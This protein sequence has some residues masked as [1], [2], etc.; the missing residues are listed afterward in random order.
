MFAKDAED[1]LRMTVEQLKSSRRFQWGNLILADL[2]SILANEIAG[3]DHSIEWSARKAL[4]TGH[5]IML[6]TEDELRQHAN[7]KGIDSYVNLTKR[8]DRDYELFREISDVQGV[9]L[10]L[11]DHGESPSQS[12]ICMHGSGEEQMSG[13]ASY[14]VEI[15]HPS[16]NGRPEVVFHVAKGNPCISIYTAIPLVFPVDEDVMSQALGMYFR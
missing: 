7:S 6:E 9:F 5:H 2:D 11:K 12:S 3:G 8:V 16:E 13:M 14:A 10:A 1:G 4:H 15:D